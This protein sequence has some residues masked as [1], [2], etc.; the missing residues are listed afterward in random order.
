MPVW[1]S[2]PVDD[3]PTITLRDW[4]F[5]EVDA[6]T[7][8]PVG[9]NVASG[10]GRVSPAIEAV[11]FL[12]ATCTDPVGTRLRAA[13]LPMPVCRRKLVVAS[14]VQEKQRRLVRRR[15]ATVPQ[16]GAP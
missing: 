3:V 13:R 14:L 2:S 16:G 8:H 15:N 4:S 9:S 11:D 7:V 5:F 12:T 10:R 6:G 1:M